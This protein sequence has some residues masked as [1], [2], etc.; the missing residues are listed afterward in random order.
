MNGSGES[1]RPVPLPGHGGPGQGDANGDGPGQ[2]G[3]HHDTGTG[4]HA[5]RTDAV[6]ADTIRSRAHGP[7][8]RAPGRPGSATGWIPGRTDGAANVRG[9]GAL[10]AAA[11][12]EIDG[13]DHSNV[14]QEYREQVRQY[15][16]P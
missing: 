15:F 14:P 1:G 8:S 6:G 16:Q 5:G 10:G 13:V 9:T 4:S 7:M 3:H 2:E 11:P 12:T